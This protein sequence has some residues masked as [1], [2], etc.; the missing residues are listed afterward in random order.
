MNRIFQNNLRS[1]SIG[2]VL[3]VLAAIGITG[4][5][6]GGVAF[7]LALCGF[8]LSILMIVAILAKKRISQ[9]IVAVASLL[10]GV[11]F[12]CACILTV[13]KYGYFVFMSGIYS[14]PVLI[15]LCLIVFFIEH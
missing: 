3:L 10:Y 4:A 15:L 2:L 7:F 1:I 11:W 13:T 8:P 14:L 12:A 9:V 5:T 6:A